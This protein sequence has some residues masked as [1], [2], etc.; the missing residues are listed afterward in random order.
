MNPLKTSTQRLFQHQIKMTGPSLT[1]LRLCTSRHLRDLQQIASITIILFF[2]FLISMCSLLLVMQHDIFKA[3]AAGAAL[4]ST[5]FAVLNW[6]YQTASKRIGSID[7]FSNEIGV[8]CRVCLIIDFAKDTVL[9]ADMDNVVIT[10][11]NHVATGTDAPKPKFASQEQYTPVYDKNI[12]DLQPF[13]ADVINSVT[14][15]YT[16]RKS[17]MDYLRLISISEGKAANDS[18]IQMIYMQYLM[19]ESA[20]EAVCLLIEFEPDQTENV[21]NILCSE[22]SLFAFLYG[23]FREDF[24]GRRLELRVSDYR[25]LIVRL[26]DRMAEDIDNVHWERARAT[27]PEVQNRYRTMCSELNLKFMPDI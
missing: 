12:S 13:D 26:K 14:R 20:R 19:F 17:M 22:F 16:Y 25:N 2:V 3:I 10:H 23:K 11:E 18:R 27:F 1:F 15:F 21:L 4:T 9:A 5:A 8:I 7:L 24:R 6:L